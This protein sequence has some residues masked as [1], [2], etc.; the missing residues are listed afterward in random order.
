MRLVVKMIEVKREN[1]LIKLPLK[2]Y[3][4]FRNLNNWVIRLFK[5]KKYNKHLFII[6]KYLK[7]IF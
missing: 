7:Y 3:K 1:Y 5:N 4:L 6:K 2:K